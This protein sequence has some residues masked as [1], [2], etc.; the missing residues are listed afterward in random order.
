M[1]D[2]GAPQ[3][4]PDPDAPAGL[5]ARFALYQRAGGVITPLLT[6]LVAFLIGGLVVLLVAGKNPLS[7]YKQIFN[8]TGLNWLW[9][10]NEAQS[11]GVTQPC[12][13]R[14][15]TSD[16]PTVQF[17]TSALSLQQTLIQLTV[18][19]LTALAV[20]FAF[21]CGL[22]NIGGQG[23]Y[24]IGLI[25]AVQ[26]GI[27]FDSLPAFLHII[28]AAAA[29]TLAGALWAGIAGILKATVGAHEV[30]TTIMLNWT[31]F[32]VGLY[33]IQGPMFSSVA[34]EAGAPPITKPIAESAK[35]PVIWGSP[36]L[37]GLHI[38]LFVALAA[39]VVYWILLNRT[40]LGFE[41][42]AVGFNPEAAAYGGI[43]VKRNY[44]LA[45]AISG[46]FAGL[47]GAIDT[48][49]WLLTSI[50]TLGHQS[51]SVGFLGIAVALLGR[52]TALGV[53][54][55]RTRLRGAD[56]GNVHAQPRSGG[57]RRPEQAGNLSRDDP[58]AGVLFV[59][60]ELVV[61]SSGTS[62]ARKMQSRQK[63]AGVS[64]NVPHR[65]GRLAD[66]S[67]DLRAR[68]SR[69]R[70]GRR[71][72]LGR[73]ATSDCS[74]HRSFPLASAGSVS[75]SVCRRG[76]RGGAPSRLGRRRERLPSASRLAGSPPGRKSAPRRRR[77]SG[78]RSFAA[79]FG[80]RPR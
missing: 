58:G 15:I 71:C 46:G 21:R 42:R 30:I 25:A 75:L 32:F 33:L 80:R 55:R 76:A 70:A 39:L 44:F 2:A 63:V 73:P 53:L 78:R 45:M 1:S 77:A 19:I 6:T 20:A 47:A 14:Q 49:G 65:S 27:W 68:G 66:V 23:Q 26:V 11:V 79:T 51:S 13:I 50:E 37:Q 17:C 41:V 16:D 59:G 38:G 3:P 4:A 34:E 12:S 10:W 18:L 48:L 60:A 36:L 52:N 69:D 35:L 24:F 43:C 5:A 31:A 54:L 7:T 29:A 9:P 61:L 28:L 22:F 72:V 8:G 67:A 62:A 57:L 64:V 56:D 40:T 74:D